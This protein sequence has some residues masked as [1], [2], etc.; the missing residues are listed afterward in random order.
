VISIAAAYALLWF[1][2]ILEFLQV[3]VFFFIV[4]LFGTV[5]LGML[6]KRASPAGGFWGFVAAILASIGMWG[7]VHTFPQGYR[8]PPKA[9]IA[10]GSVVALERDPQTNAIRRGVV[11]S[12]RVDV[13]NVPVPGLRADAAAADGAALASETVVPAD[14][15]GR[16]GN[17]RVQLIAPAV[18]VAGESEPARFGVEGVPVVLRPGVRLAASEI[19]RRFE[20]AAFNPDHTVHVARSRK[21]K[22][23]AVNMYSGWWS[24]VVCIVVTVLVSLVTKPKPDSELKNLVYGL[25]PLPDEG[26]CP[27]YQRPA[28]WAA[29]VTAALVAVNVIFW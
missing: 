7:Y 20:A 4:P 9:T 2:N 8:P 6:W 28:L 22:P 14:V 29:L 17:A 24:L 12:G 19:T 13:L 10:E 16:D 26:P 23:M 27:W 18:R 1:S 3:L 21:A 15:A 11:E 5:I 25:T